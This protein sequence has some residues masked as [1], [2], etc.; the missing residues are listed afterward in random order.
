MNFEV[1]NRQKWK[2]GKIVRFLYLVFSLQF[3]R[4]SH[5]MFFCSDE[6]KNS[7]HL[8]V[9]DMFPPDVLVQWWKGELYS[10]RSSWAV[11]TWCSSAVKKARTLLHWKF[12]RCSHLRLSGRKSCVLSRAEDKGRCW[13]FAGSYLS[14][15]AH[16]SLFFFAMAMAT[17]AR[18]AARLLRMKAPSS[19]QRS[20]RTFASGIS[21]TPSEVFL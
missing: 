10:A 21:L 16:L 15:I 3:P 4:C 19:V 1:F 13:V 6:S 9:P 18:S 7:V 20:S 12:P 11:L 17:T 14:A 5:L 2:E 8:V